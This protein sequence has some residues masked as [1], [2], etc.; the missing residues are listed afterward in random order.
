MPL[1]PQFVRP[2]A[3]RMLVIAFGMGSSYEMGLRSGL[4]VDGVELVP[5]VPSMFGYFNPNAAETLADPKGNVII[6]DGRNYLELTDKRYDIVMIDPPP[7][8]ES[9]GTA[10][11]Y[12]QE[13]YQAAAR[14]LNDD[15]VIM[16]WMP[17]GQ[18]IDEF[19]AHVR[20][21]ESV[22]P[23]VLMAFGP[24]T[25][26]V[27][28]LGSRGPVTM[29]PGAIASVLMRPGVVDDLDQAADAPVVSLGDWEALIPKQVWLSGA[30]VSRFA[31]T[32]PLIT[33]DRPLTEYFLLRRSFG[34]QS[35]PDTEENL[36]AVAGP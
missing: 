35:P 9:S 34:P 32:G 6:A 19:R 11:L 29:D 13:F 2:S 24:A 10:V 20:T 36:K 25:H 33:D 18:S 21:F 1:M 5:S 31:G 4:T 26:G 17:A 14:V 30:S 8:I 27:F 22:F 3:T 23:N 15:G 7:P 16:M 12:S 28:I